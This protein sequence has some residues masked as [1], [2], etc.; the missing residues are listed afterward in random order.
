[1]PATSDGDLGLRERLA[2]DWGA[3]RAEWA[4]AGFVLDL[5][6]AWLSGVRAGIR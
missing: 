1:V 3:L 6:I 4:K 2:G 5:H